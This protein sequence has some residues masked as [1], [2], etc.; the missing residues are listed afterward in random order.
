M[1][2]E[3]YADIQLYSCT[4]TQWAGPVGLPVLARLGPEAVGVWKSSFLSS[5]CVR[6]C[7]TQSVLGSLLERVLRCN[8]LCSCC[9]VM[10]YCTVQIIVISY[11]VWRD[12]DRLV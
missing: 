3:R 7:V 2:R 4:S 12:A 9:S 6:A 8:S 1:A 10:Y 11:C 5:V